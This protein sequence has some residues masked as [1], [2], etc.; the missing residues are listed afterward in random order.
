MTLLGITDPDALI[1]NIQSHVGVDGATA[2]AIAND[3]AVEIFN[4][5]RDE[6]E[7]NLAAKRTDSKHIPIEQRMAL[8]D[9]GQDIPTNVVQEAPKT[10]ASIV[11][12]RLKEAAVVGGSTTTVVKDAIPKNPVADSSHMRRSITNDSY[13]EQ[14]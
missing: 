7:S 12:A 3:A 13:R 5:I 10:V 1:S 11:E 6:L 9:I 4:P 2:T 14:V 8:E